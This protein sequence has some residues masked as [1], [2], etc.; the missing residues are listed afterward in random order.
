MWLRVSPPGLIRTSVSEL[1]FQA[2]Q[3]SNRSRMRLTTMRMVGIGDM[4]TIETGTI[5]FIDA[6]IMMETVAGVV[7]N[8]SLTDNG[9]RSAESLTDPPSRRGSERRRSAS[10]TGARLRSASAPI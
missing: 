9:L 5:A 8:E 6:G 7:D 3:S 4:T 1:A 10:M 2:S